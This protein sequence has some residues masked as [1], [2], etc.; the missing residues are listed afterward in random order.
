MTGIGLRSERG[1][2]LAAVMLAT[3]VVA[4]DSTVVA[5][6]VPSIVSDLG[7]FASYPWLFSVYLLT[8]A[9]TAPLY[10]K[11]AD[12]LGR[13]PVMFFGIAVFVLGS[14]LCGLTWTMTGLIIA[15]AIQGIGAGAVLPMA[16][17]IVGDIYTVAERA[18]VQ[19][20]TASVW[21]VSSVL[22]PTIG[23]LFSEYLHWRWI[24]F[25]NIPLGVVAIWM[26]RRNL[27]ETVER[28]RHTIDYAGAALLTLGCTLMILGLLGGGVSWAWASP[29]TA[30]VFGVG[31]VA[32]VG[33]V[34]VER[35]AVE[36]ILPLWV[37]SDRLLI[38]GNLA[39]MAT[40]IV[41]T[42]LSAYVPTFAQGVLGTGAFVA[43][44][45]LAGM[46]V[47]WPLAATLSGR[48]YTRIGFRRTALIG[49]TLIVAGAAWC[50]ALPSDVTVITV[51]LACLVLGA[52]LGLT[53][54]PVLVGL[55]AAVGWGQ[56]GV[57]TASNGFFRTVGSAIGAALFG[58]IANAVLATHAPLT[59]GLPTN[60]PGLYSAV[61]AVF[62]GLLVI[63]VLTVAAVAI[64][65]PQARNE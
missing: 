45:A 20:Y 57:V 60:V 41:V 9:V 56:R 10:G 29:L 46:N 8:Q 24:F 26:L 64:M 14:T 23:G 5:T 44:L 47:G 6:A 38:G 22:G 42:G 16:W 34:L 54:T 33:F 37:F 13:K 25:I 35:R 49:C 2:V 1:P 48:V 65:P 62:L 19:G 7:G 21:G 55:Q 17:T 30:V 63:A 39:G 61:H 51:S 28:R 27:H 58:A 12:V 52:G 43:G 59:H 50:A 18:R 15:R 31:S 36:P 11:Y 4:V 32:L 53:S 40:G 3:A